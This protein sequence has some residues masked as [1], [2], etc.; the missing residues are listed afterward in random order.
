MALAAGICKVAGCLRALGL[1]QLQNN[2]CA[3]QAIAS[4][5]LHRGRSGSRGWFFLVGVVSPR[6]Q[7]IG[8]YAVRTPNLQQRPYDHFYHLLCTI[9][10]IWKV[11]R[12]SDGA[13]YDLFHLI[14]GLQIEINHMLGP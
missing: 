12:T 4:K 9:P 6:C 14:F 7:L 13:N 3:S 11:E 10:R 2:A 5:V 8:W 1:H